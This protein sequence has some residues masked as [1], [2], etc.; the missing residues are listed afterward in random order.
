MGQNH[1]VGLDIGSHTVKA[2]VAEIMP[3]GKVA[4]R[5]RVVKPSRGIKRGV[6]ID[7]E[8]AAAT[9]NAV[10]QEIRTFSKGGVKNIYLSVGGSNTH[11]QVSRGIIAVARASAEVYKDDMDRVIQASEAVNLSPNRM[12]LHTV[13]R[14][15][16]V[17]GV[18][19]IHDPLGM[20]GAR[21]EVISLVIDAFQPAVKNLIK[22]VELT[23]G[24]VAGVIFSPL[25]SALSVL[26]KNQKELGVVLIDIGQGTTGIAVYEEGK[27]LHT[28]VVPVGAGHITSDL[29]IALKIPI[30][31]AEKLKLSYGYA[32]AQEV[33]GKEN[34][35]LQKID[36]D[37]KGSPSRK[38]IAGVIESRLVEICEFVSKE[39]RSI[40]KAGQLPGGV[41]V[42]GGGA[43]LP[44]IVELVRSELKLSTKIGLPLTS[45]FEPTTPDVNELL[46]SPEYAA[47]LG[48]ILWNQELRPRHPFLG[49]NVIMK[50]LKNLLP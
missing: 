39:L 35:D 20:V 32:M 16:I 43:K 31:V 33:S 4:I 38:F 28:S 1:I 21:L 23:G 6:V 30:E 18:G 14:E 3:S 45:L 5:F 29:G 7:M 48:L 11:A 17:D 13:T 19:D 27:L 25:A 10:V 8:D 24:G 46:E 15:F 9:V 22:C 34:V 26:S 36:I 49:G 12:I 44:G 2:V 42:V 40:G 37:M 50:F 47:V 41:V